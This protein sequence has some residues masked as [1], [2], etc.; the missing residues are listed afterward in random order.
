VNLLQ[1]YV[2][3]I[4]IG[5]Y[6]APAFQRGGFK[7]EARLLKIQSGQLVKL[8]GK[9]GSELSEMP[10]PAL[11]GAVAV[12]LGSGSF[13]SAYND[14]RRKRGKL[15]EKVG[16]VDKTLQRTLKK[17]LNN[18]Y[19]VTLR[20]KSRRERVQIASRIINALDSSSKKKAL[21]LLSTKV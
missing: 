20:G 17:A 10:G 21:S 13:D 6:L 7:T 4:L 8:L 16:K 19:S 15:L 12:L 14:N 9:V 5:D 1:I 18:M 11:A 2:K 3:T